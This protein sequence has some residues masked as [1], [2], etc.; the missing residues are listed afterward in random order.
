MTVLAGSGGV[1]VTAIVADVDSVT[2]DAEETWVDAVSRIWT[3]AGAELMNWAGADVQAAT[4]WGGVTW[5]AD[6]AGA[7]TEA[8]TGMEG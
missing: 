2:E 7:L 6:V 3:V 1:V 4:G 8:E 5:G